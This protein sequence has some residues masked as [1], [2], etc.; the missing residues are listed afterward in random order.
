MN[1][2][3]ISNRHIIWRFA[4]P[5]MIGLIFNSIYFIIDG[6]FIGRRLG[7]D[8]LAAA[9]VAIPVVE[10]MIAIS[11]LIS[12][13]A[14][15]VISSSLGKNDT[16]SAN[17]IFNKANMITL[18]LAAS[19]VILG[20]LLLE[21]LARFMGA[22]DLIL[23]DTMVYLRYFITA[24]PFLIFSFTL[25]TFARNDNAPRLAM[26]A[27]IVGSLS[28]ILLDWV[29]MYPLNMGMAGAALA[30]ALGPVF[31]VMILLPHFLRKKGVLSFKFMTFSL[32]DV[33]DITVKGMAAF[34]T[35]FSIGLV[36][37]FYNLSITHQ[38]LGEATLSA[39]V[40]I[41]YLAL[42][43][44]TAFLGSSQGIQPAISFFAGSGDNDRI[45]S[46]TRSTLWFNA[47]LALAF[48]ALMW[49]AG[50]I[51][52]SLFTNDALLITNTSAIAN[53]YFLNLVFAAVN[54]V[55]ATVLQALDYQKASTNLSL[56]RSTVP[57]M[58]LLVVLPLFFGPTSIWFAVIGAEVLTMVASG[59]IW[60]SISAHL[61]APKDTH[62]Q[63]I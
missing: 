49:V 26:W 8:A 39:Y 55:L 4:I 62:S 9:G 43:A 54:I 48:T 60:R 51:V 17:Q 2:S 23:N 20:N 10:I 19:V 15:V 21:P 50:P 16:N 57:L 61:D 46:L 33:W 30:T 18:I 53:I 29:F 56:M 24:S 38:G 27:L 44:L 35:N 59:W 42:I 45:V 25:S 41:G 3:K 34:I 14:G 13:G 36:T 7:P 58:V 31:S 40:I 32:K 47:G 11:M 1:Y 52:I 22:T 28:N 5:Q 63:L 37:L 6:I 12:V